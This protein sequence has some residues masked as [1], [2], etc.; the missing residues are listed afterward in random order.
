MVSATRSRKTV[1]DSNTVTPTRTHHQPCQWRLYLDSSCQCAV[2]YR[3]TVRNN[4]LLVPPVKRST[5][6]NRA[7]P[8]VGPKTWNPL[9]EDVTS[10]QS[11]YTIRCQLKTWLFKKSFPDIICDNTDCI[12]IFSL[13]LSVPTLRR[14]C[15]LTIW[16]IWYDMIRY[17][18]IRYEMSMAS[19]LHNSTRMFGLRLG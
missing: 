13:C 14:F 5:V 16:L 1:S 4:C 6:G 2:F 15:R 19:Q 3:Q 10:S 11:E 12:L 18:M 7:F 8:I 17:D 9:P